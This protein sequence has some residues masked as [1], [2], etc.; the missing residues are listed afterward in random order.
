VTRELFAAWPRYIIS[1]IV[2]TSARRRRAIQLPMLVIAPAAGGGA[3]GAPWCSTCALWPT[4]GR[5]ARVERVEQEVDVVRHAAVAHVEPGHAAVVA[6]QE[7]EALRAVR[8]ATSG[9]SGRAGWA[10]RIA[11][12]CR[13]RKSASESYAAVSAA[14]CSRRKSVKAAQE[15]WVPAAGMSARCAE[16]S[17]KT[18]AAYAGSTA[19]TASRRSAG[20]YMGREVL[21]CTS[22]P[23][24][25]SG[26]AAAPAGAHVVEEGQHLARVPDR[27]DAALHQLL[28]ARRRRQLVGVPALAQAALEGDD[29]EAERLVQ[30]LDEAHLRAVELA[31]PVPALAELHEPPAG[32]QRAQEL[33]VREVVGVRERAD[34]VVRRAH[35][36]RRRVVLRGRREVRLAAQLGVG[37]QPAAHVGGGRARRRRRRRR[38][39]LDRRDRFDGR[40]ARGGRGRV[41]GAG[42]ERRQPAAG[43]A[44]HARCQ[45]SSHGCPAQLRTCTVSARTAWLPRKSRAQTVTT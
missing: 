32:E 9:S 33:Q 22:K 2:Y 19:A 35:P 24:S 3:S 31:H 34:R 43:E 42:G 30:V 13:A 45:Y 25:V 10:R 12:R 16:S 39:R 15:R 41:A 26:R 4:G 11:A 36:R 37:E 1:P 14:R 28:G 38:R 29:V 21:S 27:E 23:A 20:R 7:V 8:S 40:G 18:R 44:P 6:G 5:G 17:A